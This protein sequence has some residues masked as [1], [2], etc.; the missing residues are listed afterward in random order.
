MQSRENLDGGS[1][2]GFPSLNQL[3]D[4]TDI[5]KTLFKPSRQ[6]QQNMPE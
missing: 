3:D 5:P 4:I 2:L 1:R 6:G